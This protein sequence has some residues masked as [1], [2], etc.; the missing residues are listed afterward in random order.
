MKRTSRVALGGVLSAVSV[1]ILLLSL[2]PFATYALP[3]FAGAVLIPLVIECG[4]KWALCAYAAVSLIA[5]LIVPDMESKMLFIAF[6]GYYPIVKAV[7]ESFKNRVFE[8]I[9]KMLMFNVAA[10]VGYTVLSYIGFSLEEF[11]IEG[12]ALPLHGFLALFLL[13]GNVIFILYDIG[14]TRALPLYFARFQPQIRRL[15]KF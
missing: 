7:L 13:A 15:L 10:V 14:V 6:F 12:V 1:V 2:F 5:L 4:K 11:R 8:W 3:P 9:A